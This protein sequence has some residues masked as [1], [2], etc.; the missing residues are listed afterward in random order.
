M[1]KLKHLQLENEKRNKELVEAL[2]TVYPIREQLRKD[3]LK[4]ENEEI[5]NKIIA[6]NNIIKDAEAVVNITNKNKLDKN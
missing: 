2:K 3:L 4:T 6:L 1:K 5:L